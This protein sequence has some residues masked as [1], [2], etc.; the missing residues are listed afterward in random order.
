MSALRMLRDEDAPP[1]D[2]PAKV[3]P[4]QAENTIQARGYMRLHREVLEQCGLY[5]AAVYGHLEDLVQLGNRTGEGCFPSHQSIAE[6]TYMSVSSVRRALD[7]LRAKGFVKWETR[8]DRT[9]NAYTLPHYQRPKP[10]AKEST[11][12]VPTERT[13]RSHRTDQAPEVRSDRAEGSFSQNEYLERSSKNVSPYGL[14]AAL[15][16]E[17]QYDPSGF[18]EKDRKIQM[19]AAKA[20]LELETPITEDEL[21]RIVR[22]MRAQTWR[23][24]IITLHTIGKELGKWRAAKRPGPDA[25]R[26]L[27][28]G[29]PEWAAATGKAVL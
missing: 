29:S 12:S 6:A 1:Y 5:G 28:V 8:G 19:H 22:W 4:I 23:T 27:K 2:A 10:G 9:S 21:R 11:E 26:A 25:Q 3:V 24:Q 20:L 15:C 18:S 17:A 14:F 16:D 13:V 7:D